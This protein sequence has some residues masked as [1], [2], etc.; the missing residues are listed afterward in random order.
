MNQ[1]QS[2]REVVVRKVG[3]VVTQLHRLEH[4]FI[5]YVLRRERG[6]IEIFFPRKSGGGDLLLYAFAHDVQL[7]LQ[8]LP[9]VAACHEELLDVGLR[10]QSILAE[11][12]AVYRH[13]SQVHKRKPFLLYLLNHNA[14]DG[15]LL[16]FVFREKDKSG[17]VFALFRHGNALQQDKLVR[18][19]KHDTRTVARLVV[20]ALGTAM[21]HVLEHFQ[22]RLDD[23]VRLPAVDVHQHSD[24]AGI[25]FVRR[26]V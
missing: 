6:D 20:R 18:Y 25:M 7:Q 1:C 26:I 23:V 4:T 10:P 5:Y 22:S 2:A 17:T 14:E 13:L 24:P 15:R 9:A 12:V 3:E 8:L 21:A 19:L 16:R 11:N